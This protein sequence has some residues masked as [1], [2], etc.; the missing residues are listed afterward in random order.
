[1]LPFSLERF[2]EKYFK[3][4]PPWLRA[5]VYL[6]LVL[7]FIHNYL[8]P[9][10]LE[11]Q[12]WVETPQGLRKP[13][14]NY[15]IQSPHSQFVTNS[16]GM[17]VLQTSRKVP[18]TITVIVSDPLGEWLGQAELMLPAPIYSSV[19]EK[20]YLL[21]LNREKKLVVAS[22]NVDFSLVSSAYADPQ[23][24]EPQAPRPVPNRH[25]V[26]GIKRLDLRESGDHDDNVG[27]VYA[28][29]YLNGQQIR[30]PKLPQKEIPSTHLSLHDNSKNIFDSLLF[31]IPYPGGSATQNL[32]IK[33]YESDFWGQDDLIGIFKTTVGA[34]EVGKTLALTSGKLVRNWP[35]NSSVVLHVE[36]EPSWQAAR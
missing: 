23:Q 30:T 35:N 17:W 36:P 33:L 9:T 5:T 8:K 27:K 16:N 26:I 18:G 13:A 32:E 4:M 21:T 28:K 20:S 1:L 29:V 15:V 6:L 7:T 12:L 22:N 10:T 2:L 31:T 19:V 25:L 11:G 14:Q 3:M 34:A 24:P